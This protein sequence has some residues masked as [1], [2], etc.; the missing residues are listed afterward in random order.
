MFVLPQYFLR[1]GLRLCCCAQHTMP[2]LLL[3][4]VACPPLPCCPLSHTQV[5]ASLSAERR[6]EFEAERL[7]LVQ[8]L[9]GAATTSGATAA[10]AVQPGLS[11]TAASTSQPASRN[12]RRISEPIELDV[13][14]MK[15]QRST[16]S[17]PGTLRCSD[18]MARYMESPGDEGHKGMIRPV[19]DVLYAAC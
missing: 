12:T 9:L 4:N 18:V 10:A 11:N 16:L 13:G 3:A 2:L 1:Q 14:A 19:L 15:Q 8:L 5:E 17:S 6:L 7:R